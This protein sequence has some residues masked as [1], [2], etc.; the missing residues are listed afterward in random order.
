MKPVPFILVTELAERFAYY[1]VTS[2]LAIFLTRLHLQKAVAAQTTQLFS[3]L[4]YLTPLIGAYLA[5]AKWGRYKTILHFCIWYILGLLV[6]TL[7]AW[8]A[9]DALHKAGAPAS[10]PAM[11]ARLALPLCL[12]GLFLGV[13]F[14]AGGIK[15]NVVVLGADQFELPAEKAA[16]DRFFSLFYWS[17]NIGATA[18]F[19]YV[20]NA[21]VHGQPPLV[22]PEFGF[23]YAFSLPTLAFVVGVAIFFGGRRR[24][25]VRPPQ[26]SALSTFVATLRAA[27]P[28]ARRRCL[29]VG[30]VLL[31][32]SI[33]T[34]TASTIAA[35]SPEL[36]RGLA[37]VGVLFIELS[38]GLLGYA[39]ADTTW[40]TG[41]RTDPRCGSSR[42]SGVVSDTAGSAALAE[43]STADA[44]EAVALAKDRRD[45]ADVMRLVPLSCCLV[46]FW[47]IYTQMS[48]NFLL[49]GCYM[50]LHVGAGTLSPA[51]LNVFDSTVIMVLVPAFDRIVYPALGQLGC[52]PGPL[53]RVG[54]GFG[55][56]AASMF[57]A[58]AVEIY[59]M[60]APTLTGA[61]A[62]SPCSA[63]DA[64]ASGAIHMK[65][66]SIW[67]Q[68][69]QYML[70]GMSEIFT[71]ITSY[72]LFYAQVPAEMRSVCQ[73][74]NLLCTSIG[75]LS[76]AGF[77]ALMARCVDRPLV[78]A[79][80]PLLTLAL[81]S[82]PSFSTVGSRM[83]ST[84][85]RRNCRMSSSCLASSWY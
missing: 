80:S 17:I 28:S 8:P 7:S 13:S 44:T 49:Q 57:C 9:A 77:N 6:T 24:Y 72:E 14:G 22:P 11:P 52:M 54:I 38:L 18:A 29:A 78:H 27:P 1:G 19:L 10:L 25:V 71:A 30:L 70:V 42:S 66:L 76:S 4:V 43:P 69:P 40:I 35:Q 55:L 2:S 47:A 60:R 81:T 34:V 31:P 20:A 53:V 59:R 39:G 73:A 65:A 36:A 12:G 51:T 67:V 74:M 75:S 63:S 68:T 23:F 56:S 79:H 26:G 46:L 83:T 64:T 85:R 48:S 37:I 62:I 16:Q 84:H 45:A 61:T 21:A 32:L 15:P 5:D 82:P 41:S 50:D 3:T 58:A 33:A